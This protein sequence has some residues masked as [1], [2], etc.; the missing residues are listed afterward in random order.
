MVLELDF[1]F[2][3]FVVSR[4]SSAMVVESSFRVDLFILFVL[5]C[6]VCFAS[7]LHQSKPMNEQLNFF[8]MG[9][10]YRIVFSFKISGPTNRH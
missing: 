6:F 10:R 1:L 4:F 7:F 8:Q 9:S 5:L 2:R 3:L